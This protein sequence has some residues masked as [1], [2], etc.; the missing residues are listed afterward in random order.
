MITADPSLILHPEALVIH[1][2]PVNYRIGLHSSAF[3]IVIADPAVSGHH[4]VRLEIIGG[5]FYGFPC[6]F[7]HRAAGSVI[8]GL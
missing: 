8:V 6:L 3:N 1:I 4:S 2:I 5:A 7:D